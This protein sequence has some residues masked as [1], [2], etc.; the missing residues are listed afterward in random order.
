MT[1]YDSTHRGAS[2]PERYNSGMIML[3]WAT[4][5]L[6]LV[7]FITAEIWDFGERGGAFRNN[8]KL[9]HYAAGILLTVVF[10]CRIVWRASSRKSLPA[11]ERGWMGLAAKSAHYALYLALIAQIGLGFTWRWSQGRA[12]DFFNLFS[13]PPLLNVSQDYRHFLGELHE[14]LAWGIIL[15]SSLHAI[16]ALFHHFVIKDDVLQRM[17]PGLTARLKMR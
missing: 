16:A 8:L 4:A 11:A 6:V 5:L 17:L 13:I 9:V 2:S 3:H 7:L 15:V 10:V 1:S 14:N 12:V